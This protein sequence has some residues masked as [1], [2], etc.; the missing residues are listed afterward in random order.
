MVYIFLVLKISKELLFIVLICET[1]G[2]ICFYFSLSLSLSLYFI[3]YLL[4][5]SLHTVQRSIF[6]KLILG[7]FKIIVFFYS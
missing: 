7:P 3:F 1:N 2:Y 5:A 4:H 6:L